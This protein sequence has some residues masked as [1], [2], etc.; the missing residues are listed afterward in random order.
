M[1][2]DRRVADWSPGRLGN[3]HCAMSG[4]AATQEQGFYCG[5]IT[6]SMF[7]RRG[8][9]IAEAGVIRAAYALVAPLRNIVDAQK[10]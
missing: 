7:A 1:R 10:L 8:R 4:P 6:L 2:L 9:R 5:I 3:K